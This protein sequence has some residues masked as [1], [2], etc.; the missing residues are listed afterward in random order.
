MNDIIEKCNL[1]IDELN[2]F[3]DDIL[4]LRSS[5]YD[6]RLELFEQE[7]GFELPVDFKFILKKFNGISLD[8]TEVLGLD[9]QLRRSSL[10]EVYKYEH[11]EV[12]DKMPIHLMPFS[13][14]GRGNHYCLNLK[15]MKDGIC[16][17]IFWQWNYDYQNEAEIEQC[18]DS[19]IDWMKEVMIDWTLEDYNYDGS[20]KQ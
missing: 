14:D 2:R 10:N 15:K 3:S 9:D 5:I 4:L 11:F 1:I 6:N 19:F 13:P 8:G 18:N 20:E 16:P 17:V 12:F 7:I